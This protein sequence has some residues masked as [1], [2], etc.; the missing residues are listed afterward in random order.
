MSVCTAAFLFIINRHLKSGTDFACSLCSSPVK[1]QEDERWKISSMTITQYEQ[2]KIY[3]YMILIL[4]LQIQRRSV[5]SIAL[6]RL[7]MNWYLS[8][9]SKLKSVS[10]HS[11]LKSGLSYVLNQS[12]SKL[13]GKSVFHHKIFETLEYSTMKGAGEFSPCLLFFVLQGHTQSRASQ[14][15]G[16][17]ESRLFTGTLH[18]SIQVL[19]NNHAKHELHFST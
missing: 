1:I 18:T 15:R 14:S 10:I 8:S 7:H 9:V 3:I 6:L 2:V 4:F 16:D 11:H 5:S 12:T 13:F 17:R 19:D